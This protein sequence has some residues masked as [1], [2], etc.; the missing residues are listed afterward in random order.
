MPFLGE[1]SALLTA[2]CWSGSSIAFA[3]ATNAIGSVQ[4][5]ISRLVFATI[6]LF[7]TILVAGMNI[8]LSSL[9]VFYLVISGF[10]GLVFGD[11][12]L[13]KSYQEIGP[14]LSMLIMS[15]A[16][17]ISTVLAYFFLSEV[18]SLWGIAGIFVT[19]AGIVLVV[20][21]RP[22]A[23]SKK[24]TISKIG[25]VYGFLGALGQ[26]VG[27]IFAKLAFHEGAIN[28]FVA[29]F[30][31]VASSMAVYLPLGF[32]TRRYI[33]PVKIF[34]HRKKTLVFTLIGA[35]LGPY[36]GITFSLIAVANTKVGIAAALMATVPILML[37]L[38][39]YIYKESLSWKAVAGACIAVAGVAILFLR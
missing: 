7:V 33:N 37:P 15:T 16:P 29:T 18:L 32:L 10:I 6:F 30:V 24:Y 17:A 27:L 31:R 13:F 35:I 11:T 38:V 22:D 20:L 25:L 23:S 19:I 12:Y 1:I 9:Q 39:R 2:V 8:S 5:N 34:S 28:G 36:F 3:A 4:V 26:G 14:R 21:E